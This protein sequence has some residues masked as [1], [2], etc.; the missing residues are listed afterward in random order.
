VAHVRKKFTLGPG[1]L[2]RDL[3]C[4]LE[5]TRVN[6]QRLFCLAALDELSDLASDGTHHFQQPGIRF[7]N[8][9]A[10]EFEHSENF[11]THQ[12]GKTDGAVQ[13]LLYGNVSLEKVGI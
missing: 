12:D 11:A 7:L 3:F 1:S 13:A 5:I 6:S 9:T 4:G 10:E 2:F 8:L